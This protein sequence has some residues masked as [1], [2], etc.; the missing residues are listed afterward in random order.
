MCIILVGR[1]GKDLH[2]RAKTQNPHGFSLYTKELGLIKAPTARE[3]DK[4]VKQF[5]IWHYRIASSGKI[6][7]DNIHPFPVAH[8]KAYLY[9]N[10]VLGRGKGDLSDTAAFAELLYNSPIETVK[11]VLRSTC[12]GQRFLLV[13]AKDPTK[14]LT[15][16]DWKVQE[17][18]LMSHDHLWSYSSYEESAGWTLGESST[19]PSKNLPYGWQ[20]KYYGEGV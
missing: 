19:K 16:G 13:D 8:G 18:V 15:Y 14:Y 11:S 20:K 6:G 17:G 1:I 9:H 2:N 3:V 4:A 12:S 10:G 5:G 7:K